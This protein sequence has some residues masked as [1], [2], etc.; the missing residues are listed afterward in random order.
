MT[1]S[2]LLKLV[3]DENKERFITELELNGDYNKENDELGEYY[4]IDLKNLI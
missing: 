1:Q 4:A 2:A 3:G